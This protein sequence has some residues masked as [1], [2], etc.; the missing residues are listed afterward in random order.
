MVFDYRWLEDENLYF[1]EG[2]EKL[3]EE[4]VGL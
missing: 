2:V 3:C 4:I 1:I